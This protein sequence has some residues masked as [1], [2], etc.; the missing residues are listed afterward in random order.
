[1]NPLHQFEIQ[2]LINL[3]LFG[4]DISFTNSALFMM[5]AICGLSA[6]FLYSAIKYRTIPNRLQALVEISY[7]LIAG[8]VNDNA[9]K[10][11]M[12]FFPLIFSVFF[13]VLG[14]NLLGMIPY[15]FTYTSHIIVTF[16]LAMMVFLFVTILGF[17]IHGVHFFGFFVPKGVSIFLTPI[18][19]P[20]EI[21]SYLSRPVSLSIR[22]FANMMAGHTML[23][24]FAGFCVSLGVVYGIA[25]LAINILL[26]GFEIVISCLQAYIFTILSCIYLN[27]AIHMH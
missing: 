19:V 12:R 18:I 6:L 24:V 23:K 7:N 2:K 27:D 1:M 14:G 22:L 25:P 11:G 9:G 16:G 17:M 8:M 15:T 13:F 5:I 20:V 10:E 26:T 21:I 3:N 4:Y